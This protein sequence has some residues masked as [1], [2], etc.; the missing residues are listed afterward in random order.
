LCFSFKD[1]T[2]GIG[3]YTAKIVLDKFGNV[4][5]EIELPDIKKFPEKSNIISLEQ[6]KVIATENKFFDEKTLINL[7]YDKKNGS[8]VWCF[9]QT[10]YKPDHTLSGWTLVID[11]HNGKVIEKYGSG[12]IWHGK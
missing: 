1:T 6:A 10:T 11:A 9:K 4:I 7:S 3:L 12:R 5:E 8:I 2:K